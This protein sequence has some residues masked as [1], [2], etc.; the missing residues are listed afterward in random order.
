MPPKKKTLEPLSN[1][2]IRRIMLQYFYLD[3]T[4]FLK[5]SL[6]RRARGQ[7]SDRSRGSGG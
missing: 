2:D 7:G 4:T 5:S 6:I 1:T 3:S